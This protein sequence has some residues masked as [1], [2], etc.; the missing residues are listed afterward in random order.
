LVLGASLQRTIF[1]EGEQQESLELLSWLAEMLNKANSL[2]NAVA[3]TE[4]FGDSSDG[5][6]P[7]Q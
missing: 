6:W 1:L 3:V 4:T 7:R 5:Q 2:L